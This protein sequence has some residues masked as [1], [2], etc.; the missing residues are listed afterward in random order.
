MAVVEVKPDPGGRELVAFALLWCVFFP[1]VGLVAARAGSGLLV[2]A[3]FAAVCFALA[4]AFNRDQPL[5]GRLVGAAAPAAA[6][7]LWGAAGALGPDP[8]VRLT[9]LV[10]TG[11]A[12]GVAGCAATLA[13]RRVGAGLYRFWMLAVLPIGWTV[14]HLLLGLAFFGVITPVGLAMRIAG[15]DPMSLRTDRNARSFWVARKRESDMR[16]YLRQF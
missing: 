2:F 4:A 3:G 5:R 9:T 11:V 8:G 16:R 10:G 14:S 15:H 1:V 6:L 13:S 7:G 12:V